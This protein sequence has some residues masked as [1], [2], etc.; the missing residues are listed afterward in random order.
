MKWVTATIVFVPVLFL[1]VILVLMI[2][3]CSQTLKDAQRISVLEEKVA[4]L[5]D[6]TLGHYKI[7]KE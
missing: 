3:T 2:L 6:V 4:W 7:T 5:E 1:A